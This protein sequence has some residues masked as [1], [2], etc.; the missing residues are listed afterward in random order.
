MIQ[1]EFR[2]FFLSIGSLFNSFS[3]FALMLFCASM[4]IGPEEAILRRT[5]PVFLWI[6]IALTVFFSTPNLLKVEEQEGLLDEVILQPSLPCSYLLIKIGAECLFIGLPLIGL[7]AL[8]S[9]FFALSMNEIVVLSLTLLIGFP[10]L[11][12][13]G[14]L[15]SLL[16]LHA[17]GGSILLSIL[18][19]PLSLPLL[20]FTISV[21]EMVR[22]GL[23]SSASFCLLTSTSI[24]LFIVS[25]G[26]GSW[27]FRFAVEG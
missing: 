24:F 12:A 7:G 15:G 5:A 17:R 6:L 18:I 26:I 9:S 23:D 1:R 25:I 16:T 4:A 14:I 2:I 22:L 27:A 11:S 3:F 19:F 13:L 10:A 21:M 8:L 20:L